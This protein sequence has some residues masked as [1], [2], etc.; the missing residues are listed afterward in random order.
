MM[1][2]V[3]L[4]LRRI[5]SLKRAG[6]LPNYPN[7]RYESQLKMVFQVALLHGL[8]QGTIYREDCTCLGFI[9]VSVSKGFLRENLGRSPMNEERP[10]F[11]SLMIL[12]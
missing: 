9:S 5:P 3:N 12:A 1:K 7:A 6:M 10:L 11:Y 2:K 4:F 8:G